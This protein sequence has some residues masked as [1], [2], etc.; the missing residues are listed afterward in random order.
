MFV[1]HGCDWS[2]AS[3]PTLYVCVFKAPDK[4]HLGPHLS[5]RCELFYGREFLVSVVR[6]FPP[7]S[8][9]LSSIYEGNFSGPP[10][11]YSLKFYCV[12]SPPTMKWDFRPCVG[13]FFTPRPA[14]GASGLTMRQPT[15]RSNVPTKSWKFGTI[16]WKSFG[17]VLENDCQKR[18]GTLQFV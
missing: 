5:L 11:N 12:L 9:D 7:P 1:G 13:A 8:W 6:A 16:L 10:W 18:V 2:A 14:D 17:K 15:N 3:D 4:T